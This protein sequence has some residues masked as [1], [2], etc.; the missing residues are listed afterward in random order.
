MIKTHRQLPCHRRVNFSQ[1]LRGQCAVRILHTA[2]RQCDALGNDHLRVAF[3]GQS[4]DHGG[5]GH[6]PHG[7]IRQ[8]DVHG[9]RAVVAYFGPKATPSRSFSRTMTGLR[10]AAYNSQNVTV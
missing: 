2:Y 8:D 5:S 10:I 6:I 7:V 9:V 4:R 1:I 3:D